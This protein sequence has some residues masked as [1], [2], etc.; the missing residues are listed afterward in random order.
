MNKW[1]SVCVAVAGAIA[2]SIPM[3]T[4]AKAQDVE[5]QL[6]AYR[7]LCRTNREGHRVA[8]IRYGILLE[9]NRARHE[10]WRRLHPDWFW[11]EH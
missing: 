4:V 8:C 10:A 7:D 9:K 5:A 1:L 11:W 2:C 6:L 3:S